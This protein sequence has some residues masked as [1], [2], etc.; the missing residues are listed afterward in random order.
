MSVS[1][2]RIGERPA[3]ARTCPMC[4]GSD[5]R[6]HFVYSEPP[7]LGVLVRCEFHVRVTTDSK[8]L[9]NLL[10]ESPHSLVTER[11]L[12]LCPFWAAAHLG[13]PLLEASRHLAAVEFADRAPRFSERPPEV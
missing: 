9:T 4:H 12:G 1:A 13:H 3:V 10:K 2:A 11:A 6:V 5:L 8:L 7:D